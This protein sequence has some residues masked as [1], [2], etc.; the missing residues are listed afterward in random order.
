MFEL[1]HVL[2]AVRD[3]DEG[4]HVLETRHGLRS[5]E[6]GRHPG[7]GTANRIVPL[8]DSYLELIAVVDRAEA[9]GSEFGRWVKA[10]TG[11][12]PRPIGWAVRTDALD[13]VASTHGLAVVSGSRIRPDGTTL[14]WRMAG[15]D[16]AMGAPCLPFFLEWGDGPYPGSADEPVALVVSTIEARGDRAQIEA[17][18]DVTSVPLDIVPG[19]PALKSVVLVDD[20]GRTTTLGRPSR[21]VRPQAR[22]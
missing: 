7:W 5:V 9:S 8:G 10:A 14:S 17:W 19:E 3:L 22:R 4:S 15:L 20:E 2:I 12:E 11:S 6:G 16:A 18:L 21:P 13:D 1:D